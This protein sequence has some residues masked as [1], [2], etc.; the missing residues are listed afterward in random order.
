MKTPPVGAE[1]F[2]SDRRTDMTMQ[3][4]AFAILRTRLKICNV[5]YQWGFEG[6]GCVYI[7]K[8]SGKPV[9]SILLAYN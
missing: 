3:I 1:L 2:H 7:Q 5:E 6:E 8:G 4:V 9:D